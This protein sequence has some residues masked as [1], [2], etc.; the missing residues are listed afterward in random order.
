MENIYQTQKAKIISVSQE[1]PDTMLFRFKFVNRKLQKSFA[2]LPGQFMQIGMPGWG[3]CPISI[4]SS[5]HDAKDF[6]ELAIRDVGTL[7]HKLNSLEVADLVDVRGPYGNGFDV[8]KFIDKPLVIIGGG[9]GFVPLRPLIVDYVNGRIKTNKLQI[10]YGCQNEQTLLFK[11]EHPLW[12]RNSEFVIALEKPSDKWKGEKGLITASIIKRD[13]DLKSV[14]VIVGPPIMY[15]F[16]IAELVKKK[17][18]PANIYISLERKMYCGKG[19]CQHCA[20]GPYY[21]CKDGPVFCWADI[22]DIPGAI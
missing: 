10:F 20:I 11:K 2:F 3:E 21:V 9:C 1:S 13:I 12:N 4:C 22:K 15:K 18:K 16:V 7:T 5:S 8:D 6:F 19:V 14:V 17:I